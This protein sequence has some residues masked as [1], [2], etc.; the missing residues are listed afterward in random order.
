MVLY[1]PSPNYLTPFF[2]WG[3]LLLGCRLST[4]TGPVASDPLAATQWVTNGTD[5]LPKKRPDSGRSE[6]VDL[7][8]P[9]NRLH[10]GEERLALG[11]MGCQGLISLWR[12]GIGGSVPCTCYCPS[13]AA[14]PASPQ[15]GW[16]RAQRQC[17]APWGQ[18]LCALH[19]GQ[20]GLFWDCGSIG[21]WFLPLTLERVDS[22]LD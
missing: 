14:E 11:A 4:P 8:R 12:G 19:V 13:A 9:T 6:R 18:C 20:C 1:A 2:P 7:G 15:S 22:E 3:V 17:P 5:G 16:W 10:V 21:G